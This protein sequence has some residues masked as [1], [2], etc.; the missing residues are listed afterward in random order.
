MDLGS[1]H[2]NMRAAVASASAKLE[3]VLNDSCVEKG[4]MSPAVEDVIAQVHAAL[5]LILEDDAN[6]S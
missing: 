2:A 1:R 4:G 6:A 3:K 5:E